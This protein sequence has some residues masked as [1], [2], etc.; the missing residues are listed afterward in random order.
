MV[1]K[2][3]MRWAPKS[4]DLLLQVRT[5]VLDNERRDAFNRWYPAFLTPAESTTEPTKLA[6]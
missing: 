5:R 1:K 6:A 2:Q 4:A 3:Q